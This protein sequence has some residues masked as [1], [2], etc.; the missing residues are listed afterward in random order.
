MLYKPAGSTKG[1]KIAVQPKL[2]WQ[3]VRTKPLSEEARHGLA[4][5]AWAKKTKL[6]D[7]LKFVD[8]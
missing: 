8:S 5:L 1:P 7:V 2:A 3:V 4:K 6:V